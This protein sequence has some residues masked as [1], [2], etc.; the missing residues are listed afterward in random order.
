MDQID[1]W[2]W[3]KRGFYVLVAALVLAK[4]T[5]GEA[6]GQTAAAWAQ[7]IGSVAAIAGAAWVS[8]GEARRAKAA[9][10]AETRA[11]VDA[12]YTELEVMHRIFLAD[13]LNP[14]RELADIQETPALS[15]PHPVRQ[16]VFVVYPNNA[17]RV[18]RIDDE[19]LRTLIVKTYDR[20]AQ[21][22]HAMSILHMLT[23]EHTAAT[24]TVDADEGVML[25]RSAEAQKGK[26]G[27]TAWLSKEGEALADNMEVLRRSIDAWKA[28]HI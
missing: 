23:L 28:R 4:L 5:G 2:P 22:L 25:A 15:L 17:A 6:Y 27:Y 10:V 1:W 9:D 13:V 20:A 7:A 16:S 26:I 11:F 19:A 3:I 12:V 14:L 18:G 21:I 24:V 8:A